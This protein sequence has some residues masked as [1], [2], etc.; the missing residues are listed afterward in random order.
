MKFTL[1]VLIFI[2][3]FSSESMSQATSSTG[4]Y[5]VTTGKILIP[6]EKTEIPVIIK[7]DT[8]TGRS[9]FLKTAKYELMDIPD[10]VAGWVEIVDDLQKYLLDVA[11]TNADYRN[12]KKS[13]NE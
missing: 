4:R 7:I 5:Q 6:W 8:V 9:W 11:D 13:P 3:V 12:K 10:S 1:L 2:I